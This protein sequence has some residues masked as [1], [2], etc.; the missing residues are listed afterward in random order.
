MRVVRHIEPTKTS[1]DPEL[2]TIW[3]RGWW[4]GGLCHS[5]PPIL[6]L[7]VLAE[8][9]IVAGWKISSRSLS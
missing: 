3:K 9:A 7:S 8:V 1:M 4:C 6:P 2:Y 5:V